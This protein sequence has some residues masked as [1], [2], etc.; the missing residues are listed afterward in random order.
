[1]IAPFCSGEKALRAYTSNDYKRVKLFV[2]TLKIAYLSPW[3]DRNDIMAG[4]SISVEIEG[5]INTSLM[6]V[7]FFSILCSEIPG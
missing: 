6:M 7:V 5:T 1:M 2:D 4:D 3:F